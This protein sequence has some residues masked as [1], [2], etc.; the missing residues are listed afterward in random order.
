M[1]LMGRFLEK[2]PNA[3][4]STKLAIKLTLPFFITILVF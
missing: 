3:D 2:P 4:A 1:R